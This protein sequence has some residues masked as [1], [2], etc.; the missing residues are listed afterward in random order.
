LDLE[1]VA[2]DSM[3]R[4]FNFKWYRRCLLRRYTVSEKIAAVCPELQRCEWLRLGA[5]DSGNYQTYPFVV[6]EETGEKVVRPVM[7]WWMAKNFGYDCGGPLP[8][9]LVAENAWWIPRE[10]S[11]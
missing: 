4:N 2:Q 8:E 7:R 5:D 6:L 1:Q 3:R 10:P 11:L 9:K